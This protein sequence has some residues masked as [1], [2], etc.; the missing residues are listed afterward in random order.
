MSYL[1]IIF[2][3]VS[4]GLSNCLWIYPL[5]RLS[6]L[7]V[8][9]LRSFITSLLFGSLLTLNIITGVN[10]TNTATPILFTEILKAIAISGFSYFG[11]FFYV[12]SLREEKVS[13]AVPVSSISSLFGLLFAVLVLG[14]AF[15][16]QLF[17]AML[18]FTMGVY[19]IDTSL[20]SN[21]K[22]SNGVSYNL[23][24][25]FFWGTSFAMFTYP[26]K[27]I[28]AL[29][30]SFVLESTVC[31]ASILLNRHL[32]KEWF[33]A[34]VK[35]DLSIIFLAVLGFSGIVCYNLSLSYLT[36]SLIS[37]LGII[38]PA[39]S[40]LISATLLKE[41]L[42]LIQYGGIALIF[43]GLLIIKFL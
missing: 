14:E 2:S 36:V 32:N 37:A 4:F 21:F 13:I 18:L 6:F 30:F 17:F 33:L 7:Q 8:I 26:V 41:R 10:S 20:K 35:I 5:K 40:I 27:E 29:L 42:K 9:I 34:L 3:I 24:A 1:F 19:F 15:S 12:K 22:L 28:G 43:I 39:V 11:L 31:V 16:I 25:A 23:L 38:T